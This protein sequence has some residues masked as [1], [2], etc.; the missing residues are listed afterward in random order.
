MFGKTM[1]IAKATGSLH[2]VCYT[3]RRIDVQ[4]KPSYLSTN[5][6]SRPQYEEI[7]PT[8]FTWRVTDRKLS[9][10]RIVSIMND[11]QPYSPP[12]TASPTC[13]LCQPSVSDRKATA[14]ELSLCMCPSLRHPSSRQRQPARRHLSSCGS[15]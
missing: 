7:R 11:A 9:T 5:K 10:C 14:A 2:A 1:A 12:A 15:L 4:F 8:E 6:R 13:I 3:R